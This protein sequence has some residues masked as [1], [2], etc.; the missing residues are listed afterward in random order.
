MTVQLTELATDWTGQTYEE[1]LHL[2]AETLFFH[3]L[4]KDRTYHHATAQIRARADIQRNHRARL[5][6]METRNG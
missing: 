2:C 3:G 5:L 6:R 1:R 4:L